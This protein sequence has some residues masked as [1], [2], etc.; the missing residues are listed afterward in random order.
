MC[1]YASLNSNAELEI[2][3]PSSPDREYLPGCV[4]EG[5]TNEER[6]EV[7]ELS[8]LVLYTKHGKFENSI[9]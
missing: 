7:V 1:A 5:R 4:S 2:S 9:R 3:C 6:L 8:M